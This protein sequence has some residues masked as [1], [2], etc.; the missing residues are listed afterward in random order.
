MGDVQKIWYV[1][2][3]NDDVG[4]QAPETT[5]SKNHDYIRE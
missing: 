1:P 2:H 5:S 4:I 3:W